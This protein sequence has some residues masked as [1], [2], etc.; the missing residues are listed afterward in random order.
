MGVYKVKEYPECFP[1]PWLIPPLFTSIEERSIKLAPLLPL[2]GA[3]FTLGSVATPKRLPPKSGLSLIV[4]PPLL[5]RKE[6]GTSMTDE[7]R[8]LKSNLLIEAG[9]RRSVSR[10]LD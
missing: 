5:L 3:S 2:L 4:E 6:L 9:C 10:P 1:E 7:L 8:F